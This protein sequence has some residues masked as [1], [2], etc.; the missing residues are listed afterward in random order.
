MHAQAKRVSHEQ[1]MELGERVKGGRCVLSIYLPVHFRNCYCN[2]A[3]SEQV[4]ERIK[5]GEAVF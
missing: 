3:S 5:G 4:M 2:K 1:V